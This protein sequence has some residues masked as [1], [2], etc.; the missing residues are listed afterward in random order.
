VAEQETFKQH[1][2][3]RFRRLYQKESFAPGAIGLLFNPYYSIRRRLHQ[4]VRQFAGRVE[5]GR[6]LDL[7][8]GS[9]PYRALFNVDEYIGL[10]VAVSGH[11]H[12]DSRIDVY[13]DGKNIPFP[14]GCFDSVLCSE[15]FEH[16]FELSELLKEI[17]RVTRPGGS[18]LITLPF[19]W[20]EHEVPFDYARYTS[21]GIADLLER[22]GFAVE[23]H[24]KVSNTVE[25]IFQMLAAYVWHTVFPNPLVIKFLL[26]PI[27]VTPLHIL[28]AGLGFLFPKDDTIY[29][30]NVVLCRKVG[31]PIHINRPSV[32]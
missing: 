16:V 20:P 1:W 27:L 17:N 25:T 19:I 23:A 6:M 12:F 21:Y 18:L 7:G 10:D 4:S 14:D 22:S 8:C 30:S 29:Q 5:G 9:K 24:M 31:P 13:Y 11:D 26:T 28:G 3:D 32:A 15:V 2:N